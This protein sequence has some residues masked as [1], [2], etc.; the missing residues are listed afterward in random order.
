MDPKHVPAYRHNP[1]L[2]VSVA[3][4]LARRGSSDYNEIA[5]SIDCEN[6]VTVS[7]IL[8]HIAGHGFAE[9]RWAVTKKLSDARLTDR[10][11]PF[12]RFVHELEDA[13]ADGSSLRGMEQEL[14]NLSHDVTERAAELYRGVSPTGNARSPEYWI[15]RVLDFIDRYSTS[16]GKGPRPIEIERGVEYKGVEIYLRPLVKAGTLAKERVGKEVRYRRQ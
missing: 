15:R 6:P 3:E 1:N 16:H 9:A 10:G 12:V 8:S 5:E 11:K 13:L 7:S 2:T 4:E 14:C